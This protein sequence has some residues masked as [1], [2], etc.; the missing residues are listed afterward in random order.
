MRTGLEKSTVPRVTRYRRASKRTAPRVTSVRA[1]TIGFSYVP[2]N[3]MSALD[4]MCAWLFSMRSVPGA[5]TRTSR[6]TGRV[7]GATPEA[8]GVP[9]PPLLKSNRLPLVSNLVVHTAFCTLTVPDSTGAVMRPVSAR[10][11]STSDRT[12][13]GYRR[14]IFRPVDAARVQVER[15]GDVQLGAVTDKSHVVHA[16]DVLRH[17]HADRASI[18]E[19]IVKQFELHLLEQHVDIDAS[20]VRELA[21]NVQDAAADD[22]R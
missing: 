19:G 13:S 5:T 17:R 8:T 18:V 3:V 15:A 16:H 14:R 11:A 4:A 22:R 7:S 6:R 9:P 21:R 12:P 1:N 2:R 10:S 20:R